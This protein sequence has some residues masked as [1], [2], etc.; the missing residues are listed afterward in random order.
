MAAK[1]LKVKAVIHESNSYPGLAV[2]MLA[3]KVKTIMLGI[4]VA[5]NSLPSS[6]NIVL[7]GTPTQIERKNYSEEEKNEIKKKMNLN[8][9]LKTVLVFGGSQGAQRINEAMLRIVKDKLFIN[10]L[11]V[12][13]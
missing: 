12:V 1:K 13:N 9:E 8:P 5:R 11:L 3:K 6:A 10:T 7:T 2:K 4:D